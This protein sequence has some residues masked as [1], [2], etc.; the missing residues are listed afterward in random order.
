L[1]AVTLLPERA[2]TGNSPRDTMQTL[3]ID[4]P[5]KFSYGEKPAPVAAPGE[6]LLRLK[7][8]G[9][10]G[11]DL[12]TF[13][14]GNPLV[15]Y[16][17]VPGHEIAAVIAAVT[18]GV[19]ASLTVGQEVTVMPYTTCG[20]CTSCRA[21]RVNACRHNQTLGVQQEGAFTEFI[22]V[23]WQKIVTA[24]LGARELALV[25]PLAVGFHAVARGRVTK[26]DIVLVFGCGM[27]G[28]GAIAAAGLHRGAT[29]IAVDLE[30]AKLALARRAGATHTINSKT[31]NLHERL[32]ALTNGDGPHVAIEAVGTPATFVAAIEEV[33]F[34]GRVVY[35]GYAKAPVSYETKFFV[36]KELDILGSRNST[37]EDFRAVIAMLESGR[38]PVAET[39]TRTV[40]FAEAG[41]A[42][43]QWA[44]NPGVITK[45][46]VELA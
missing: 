37:A 36:M 15:T 12:G 38:Y 4:A 2:G 31:E 7:R 19:P 44:D 34:A 41:A 21:G 33:C 5:G 43:Q 16:P 29:V 1:G 35:I 17:R 26:N 9:F 23:P 10:C 40:P 46:H 25:E 13:R 20:N 30:D 45:I 6:V 14:G 8:L 27:I 11:T 24:R 22:V 32:L 42:L 18:V 39:V 28:L 3:V